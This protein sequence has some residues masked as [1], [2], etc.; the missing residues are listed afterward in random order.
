MRSFLAGRARPYY[1]SK[2]HPA[3]NSFADECR[4][5]LARLAAYVGS[6]AL[7][8]IVG[9]HLWDELSA[10]LGVEPQARPGWALATRSHPA[11]AVSQVDIPGKTET[12][13]IFRHPEGGRKDVLRWAGLGEKPTIDLE[14][15]RAGSEIGPSDLTEIAARMDPEGRRELE[16]AGVIDS[17]FGAVT[18]LRLAGTADDAG[19]CLGFLKRLNEPHLRIS[20]WS[21]QGDAL[22]AR[23]AAIGCILSRLILLTSGNEPKLAELFARA[24]LRRASCA[25]GAPFPLADWVSAAD[26][27]RL[28]GSL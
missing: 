14:I 12:Y 6:L 22:P 26:N 5:M 18:L 8:A 25:S 1:P 28:R 24:E 9:L 17:K 15:Y 7:L 23:R 16:A 11:F 19:S 13:D 20:G 4:S 2:I 10:D 21:C 3:L 27:P